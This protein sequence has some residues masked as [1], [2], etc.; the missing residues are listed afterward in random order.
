MAVGIQDIFVVGSILTKASENLPCVWPKDVLKRANN[1]PHGSMVQKVLKFGVEVYQHHFPRCFS[2][3]MLDN[4][5]W[6]GSWVRVCT[7]APVE[8]LWILWDTHSWCT[9]LVYTSQI[10]WLWVLYSMKY[11]DEL[12]ACYTNFKKSIVSSCIKDQLITSIWYNFDEFP[13]TCLGTQV[14]VVIVE[15]RGN[16]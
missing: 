15:N 6:W 2:G 10:L 14:F 8:S 9:V 7:G 11:K 3:T 12:Y 5:W 13:P 4:I 1:P 16:L